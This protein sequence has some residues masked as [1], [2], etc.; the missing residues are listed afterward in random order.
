VTV[1]RQEHQRVGLKLGAS[2]LAAARV[3]N[4]GQPKLV[5]LARRPLPA[6][7]IAGGDIRDPE[8]LAVELRAF[9]Q[10]HKLPRT[11]VR[12]GLANNRIG[13]RTFELAGVED[14]KQLDNAVRFRAQEALPIPVEQ[15]V[16]DYQVLAEGVDSAGAPTRR[17][18]L[19]V[20]Y[21]DL[22]DRYVSVFTTAGITLAG[23]DLEAF[24]VLRALGGAGN[25]VQGSAALVAVAI[26][27]D[28]STL[29]VSDGR[30]CEFT[31]VLEWGGAMLD[32]AVARA[33]DVE[34]A[35]AEPIK[36]ALG[37]EDG[38]AV[39]LPAGVTDEQA[40]DAR[41]LMRRQVQA[42]ARDLVSSLQF[43]QGQPGSLGIGELIV[44]GGTSQLRGLPAE[45]QRLTGVPVRVG[46]PLR[47]VEMEPALGDGGASGS[48]AVAIGLGIDD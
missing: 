38:E 5:H 29:A 4:N 16:L 46:D 12:I 30:V 36:R 40:S 20:A 6:G 15:A 14:P 33:L 42:F 19:V 8:A 27:Y 45:L 17:I 48:L 7:L 31:R 11:G 23:I 21:R 39:D 35:E 18:L 47:R 13:V 37:L 41:G 26:G 34:P 44:T 10:E 1:A 24:A 22:I 43:Y 2:Q 9:F 28:R 25:G 3:V 32:S